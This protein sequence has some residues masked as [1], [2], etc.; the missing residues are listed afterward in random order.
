MPEL[1][2]YYIWPEILLLRGDQMAKGH[3]VARSG[4]AKGNVMGRSHTNLI[5]DTR[6]Y[7]VEFNGGQVTELTTNVIAESM[8]TQCNTE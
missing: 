6:M 4:D 5:L 2:N 1:G 3:V 7:Q 8:Y